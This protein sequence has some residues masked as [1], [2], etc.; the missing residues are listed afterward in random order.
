VLSQNENRG[1]V[2]L[3]WFQDLYSVKQDA[4]TNSA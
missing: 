2:I 1:H 4:E 3:N